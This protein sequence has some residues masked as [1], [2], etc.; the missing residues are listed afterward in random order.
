MLQKSIRNDY[1]QWNSNNYSG[2]E[3]VTV[4]IASEQSSPFC[5]INEI[6]SHDPPPGVLV[7]GCPIFFVVLMSLDLK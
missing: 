5:Q 1:T 6:W 4:G 2:A 7:A 3:P